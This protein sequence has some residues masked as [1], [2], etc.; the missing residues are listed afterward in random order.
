MKI[1][2]PI[3]YWSRVN[4]RRYLHAS[5]GDIT[6]EI[7]PLR[8]MGESWIGDPCYKARDIE[9]VVDFCEICIRESVSSEPSKN[10]TRREGT[11]RKDSLGDFSA[12]AVVPKKDNS[13]LSEQ[14]IYKYYYW[15][16]VDPRCGQMGMKCKWLRRS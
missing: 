12:W 6:K 16:S 10:G 4:T 13:F 15:M 5:S 8:M 14:R 3:G 11:G 2:K 9:E 1:R 7:P